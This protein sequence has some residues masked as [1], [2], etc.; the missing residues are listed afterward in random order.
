VRVHTSS[1]TTGK[2]KAI[3]FSYKGIWAQAELN[4]RSLVMSGAGP[5][6]IFQNSM[7]YGFFTGALGMHYGDY[8]AGLLVIPARPGNNW[9]DAP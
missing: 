3:Y 5:G 6:D 9:E 7:T 2:P 1:G 4:T 8:L